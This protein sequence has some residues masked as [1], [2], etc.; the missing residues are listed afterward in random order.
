MP[1]PLLRRVRN[2]IAAVRQARGWSQAE[3][4]L[5]LG[6]SRGA[7]ASWELDLHLLSGAIVGKMVQILRC[8]SSD[9]FLYDFV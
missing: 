6:V 7:V 9:L 8:R 5:R 3:L 4:A 2:R 1:R